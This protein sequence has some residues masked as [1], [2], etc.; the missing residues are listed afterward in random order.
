MIASSWLDPVLGIDVHWEMVPTPAPVPTPFPHPYIGLVLDPAGLATSMVMNGAMSAVFGAPF[1]GPVLHWCLPATNTGT[2][3]RHVPGHFIIPPGTIWAPVPRTPKPKVRPGEKTVPA[4][5]IKPENDG[6]HIFG[7]KTVHVGG[8]NAVRLGDLVLSCSEPVRLPSSVTLAIPKGPL[9]LVGGPPALDLMSALQASLKTRYVSDSLHA[10]VSRLAPGR[11]RNLLHRTVCFFTGH[12]VDV[13]SGKVMTSAIDAALPGPLPLRIERVYSSAFGARDGPLGHGWSLSLDQAIW[14]ERGKVVLLEEDGREIEFDAFDLPGHA[15]KAGDSLRHPIERATLRCLGEGRWEVEAAGGVTREFAPVPG[16]DDGRAPL[17]RI[18]SACG[19]HQIA[20]EY[21]EAGRLEWVRDAGGRLVWLAWG[22]DGRLAA[23]KLPLPDGQGF[24]THRQYAY[25][26]A[27]DLVRVTDALRHSWTFEYATHLLVRET[28]RT[29]LSFYF[30]YDGMGQDAWCTRTWGDGGIYDHRLAYDKV[31]KVTWV[32]DSL[33]RTTQYHMNLAGLVVKV[34]DPAGAERKLEYD[35]RTLQKTADIDALGNARRWEYDARGNPTRVTDPTGATIALEYDE[36]GRLTGAIDPCGGSWRWERRAVGHPAPAD[37]VVEHDPRGAR[38]EHHRAVGLPSAIVDAAGR[39]TEL[40]HDEAKDLV[41]VQDGRGETRVWR[42]ALGRVIK[43]R[44]ARAGTRSFKLDLE[45]RTLEIREPNGEVR[46]FAYDAEGNLLHFRNALREVTYAYSGFHRLAREEERG[47]TVAV[48]YDTEGRLTSLVNERGERCEWVRDLRGDVVAEIGLDGA[49]RHYER[50][51]LG[52]MVRE[53]RPSGATTAVEYDA[54]GRVVMLTHSDGTWQRFGYW[55]DGQLGSAE[56][57]GSRVLLRRDAVGRVVREEQDGHFVESWYGPDGTREAMTSSLGTRLAATFDGAGLVERMVLGDPGRASELGF[58]RDGMGA[59]VERRMPGGLVARWELGPS[60]RPTAQ[61]VTTPDGRPL[62]AR[63]YTWEADAQLQALDDSAR[64]TTRFRHDARGW[65]IGW[66]GPG[67][68]AQH[69][70]PDAM[71]N[72]Y[73]SPGREDREYL[74][75][76]RLAR[77]DGFTFGYD[78]DGNL[79]EKRAPDG[80]SWRY[81]WSAAGQLAAVQGPDGAEV[82]FQYDALGRRIRKE[83][84]TAETRFVWDGDVVLHELSSTEGPTTWFFEPGTQA[85]VAK[86]QGGSR[87]SILTDQ[88]GTPTEAFDEAGQL[89]WSMQLDA[90]GVGKPDVALTSCPWRW[91]GQ[92]EDPETGL[93]YNRF[94]YYDPQAGTYVSRDPIGMLGGTNPYQYVADP[95]SLV[96]PFGLASEC[97]TD[98]PERHGDFHGPWRAA[99]GENF[100]WGAYLRRESGTVPPADMVRPHAHHAVQ[101]RGQPGRQRQ[102]VETAH[103]LLRRRAGIDPYFSLDNLG[104][105]PNRGH[106][107]AVLQDQVAR[108][109]AL[110]AANGTPEQFV[111]LVRQFGAEAAGR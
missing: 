104:W 72:V 20:F 4:P 19:H 57:E 93:H 74:P 92:F 53:T 99:P 107:T 71:G 111:D 85:P 30:E 60:G 76:G 41:S 62:V 91:P 89:A 1:T 48:Q 98:P 95:T 61:Q 67:G 65:L 63:R 45:G 79:V 96:D 26:A 75:G 12:P 8:S 22:A 35:P 97:G 3:N 38:I 24:Y 87:W 70:I 90:F 36:R 43:L 66:E 100:D 21:D 31:K 47:A 46:Q 15:M 17:R 102:L 88:L 51:A 10:L 33:G 28:D 56:T 69:R 77:A 39:R 6:V 50:D 52:R 78:P 101:K 14:T 106:T 23:L 94:R 73:R 49:T 7:S 42:D 34:V 68:R 84:D 32:T 54:A 11:F 37:V 9:I 18:R 83:T 80:T 58:V 108:L 27:G 82:R 5:P 86:E 29:G 2:E 40:T 59:E 109:Q 81:R 55:P 110:D 105:A 13:A 25:G 16:R 64:G 44:D 103:D